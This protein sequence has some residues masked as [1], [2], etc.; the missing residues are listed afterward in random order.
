MAATIYEYT[1]YPVPKLQTKRRSE[2]TV[3]ISADK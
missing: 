2:V 1:S 3:I